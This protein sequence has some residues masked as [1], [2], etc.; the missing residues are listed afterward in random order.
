MEV[1]DLQCDS[2]LASMYHWQMQ[3]MRTEFWLHFLQAIALL[4]NVVAS[5]YSC[6]SCE[7]QHC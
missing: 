6:E 1:G 3:M 2:Q 5:L 4:P 7:C